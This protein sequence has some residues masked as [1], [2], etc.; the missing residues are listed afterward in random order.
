VGG[1][2]PFRRL[3]APQRAGFQYTVDV[4]TSKAIPAWPSGLP[5]GHARPYPAGGGRTW[6][7]HLEFTRIN[8]EPTILRK[9]IEDLRGMRGGKHARRYIIRRRST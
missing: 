8:I 3:E 9:K 6:W 2:G 4:S 1:H 5:N 7:A